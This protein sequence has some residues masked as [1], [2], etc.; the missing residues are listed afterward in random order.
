MWQFLIKIKGNFSLKSIENK[1]NPK[2][3]VVTHNNQFYDLKSSSTK[4]FTFVVNRK[5]KMIL[6]SSQIVWL[7][8]YFG[9][10]QN[11]VLFLK[12]NTI[13]LLTFPLYP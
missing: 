5:K 13:N 1:S 4:A 3:K 2:L 6:I 10:S 11:Y 9:M 7:V 8:F 12:S